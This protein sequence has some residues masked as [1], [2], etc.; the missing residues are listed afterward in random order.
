MTAELEIYKAALL[1]AF[2]AFLIVGVLRGPAQWSAVRSLRR[3]GE[4]RAAQHLAG[5]M[6]QSLIV[7][8][9]TALLVFRIQWRTDVPDW[10][11]RVTLW[12]IPA[13]IVLYVF[14]WGWT[15]FQ[16]GRR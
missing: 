7:F 16:A 12:S 6:A 13:M 10:F 1:V 14:T 15:S 9:F 11:N 3:Q 5:D 8:L 4:R 2:V